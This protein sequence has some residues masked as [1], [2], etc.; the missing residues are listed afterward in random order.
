MLR[1]LGLVLLLL[2]MGTTNCA[3]IASAQESQLELLRR[4]ISMR[5]NKASII[6]VAST[7]STEKDVPIGLIM[8]SS[9]NNE[10]NIDINVTAVPLVELLNMIVQQT[11]VYGWEYRDGVINFYPTRD[12]DPFFKKLL[13]TQVAGFAPKTNN[14]FEI[15]NAILDLPEVKLLMAAEKVKAERFSY[16][17]YPSIYANNANLNAEHLDVKS[18]LNK[19]IR[20]SEHNLYVLRWSR[21]DIR[22]FELGF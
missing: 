8:S 6:L 5:L 16:V 9:G 12:S 20:E 13:D 10:P 11:K 15:R 21:K 14:K 7:L 1:M 3:G 19:I 2:L 18:L 17:Y 4:P 22:E